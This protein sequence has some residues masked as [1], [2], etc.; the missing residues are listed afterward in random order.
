MAYLGLLLL[1]RK[2]PPTPTQTSQFAGISP[3]T[4][5]PATTCKYKI[6][7]ENCIVKGVEEPH[8]I[9]KVPKLFRLTL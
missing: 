4:L 7:R 6:K 9:I 1:V 5:A 8:H 3:A 2:M